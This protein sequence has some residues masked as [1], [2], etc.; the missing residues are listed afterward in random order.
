M[1]EAS[2]YV[3]DTRNPR[4]VAERASDAKSHADVP[5]LPRSVVPP[6]R[7]GDTE[8]QGVFPDG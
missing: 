4:I 2:Q 5:V 3:D 7:V 1:D 8:P 6:A